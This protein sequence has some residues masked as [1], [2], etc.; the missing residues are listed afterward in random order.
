MCRIQDRIFIAS[1]AEGKKYAE[2][3]EDCL[4]DIGRVTKW[5]DNFFRLGESTLENLCKQAVGFDYAVVLYTKDDHAVIRKKRCFTARDNVLFEHG[6]FTGLLSRYRTF[7]LIQK[8]V[9]VP[10]DLSGITY[11]FFKNE[12]DLPK[13]CGKIA[14]KIHEER[15]I[16]RISMLPSTAT[17]LSYFEN[18]VKPVCS[19]L[20]TEDYVL[21]GGKRLAF[22]GMNQK[23]NIVL[24]QTLSE[25]L[26][27]RFYE[28]KK[29]AALLEIQ[30]PGIHRHFTGYGRLTGETL[31]SLM[32]MPTCLNVSRKAAELYMGKDFIGSASHMDCV[33]A[34]EL[35]NFRATLQ[36]LIDDDDTARHVACVIDE[37]EFLKIE[38]LQQR[39]PALES[40]LRA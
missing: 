4:E 40:G 10:S 32:D 1:S 29:P 28:L 20:L 3:V 2:I 35:E 18:F 33:S 39:L 19:H 17:A 21:S 11:V 14:D 6:I 25:D 12:K 15:Q 27:P 7:A 36:Y 8:G 31:Y 9:R 30:I 34:R 23:L 24:P 37:K 5:S 22:N 16:S 38:V 13:E 26:K